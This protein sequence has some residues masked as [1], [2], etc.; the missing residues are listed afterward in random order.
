[1]STPAQSLFRQEVLDARSDT[2]SGPS[3]DIRPVG[4]AR[5]TFFFLCLAV[6]VLAVLVFGHYTKKERVQGVVQPR[7][8]V[9]MVVPLEPGIVQR[10]LVT[11]GQ[12]VKAGDVIAEI[13]N[14]RFSDAGSTQALLQ[15]NLEGQRSQ[16][17]NQAEG[18]AQASAASLASLDQR[19][20]QSRRDLL[21][22]GEEAQLQAQQIASARKLVDQFKPLLDER[23]ISDLQ[24]EQQ[25]QL[26]LDQTA[27]L[28][29][30]KRQRSA[31]EADLASSQDD[32]QRLQAQLR[33]D[34]ASLGRDLL[35]LQQ[36]E[37]Q[38][39]GA[40]RVLLKA[41][42]DGIVSG[43]LATPG[44]SVN[45]NAA[46]ASIVPTRSALEAT[47]YLP[48]TSVGFIKA[49][50]RV[51]ISYDAFPHQRFGQYHGTVR[52]VSQTDVPMATSNANGGTDR[53]AVFIVRVA[54]D[55]PKVRAYGTDIALRPGHTLTADIEI[56]RRRLIRW[57][58]DPLFAFSGKL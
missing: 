43:L 35:S 19:I 29:T 51:R 24:Y 16:M 40:R 34:Q 22:L 41:P 50:Q 1:M 49:G 28:Q 15:M 20:A 6:L 56:D 54:L 11:E 12:A 38:R 55:Q 18:Q 58:L 2:S 42:V 27:R 45:A 10:V 21:T 14:E 53:R 32:R 31:A 9:A 3:I 23:I 36:E 13:S 25:R 57:M 52:S 47:L 4:A 46:L 26:L 8:G 33:I 17:R 48:S 39:H 44:Q 7:D 30:L 5:L 37:V